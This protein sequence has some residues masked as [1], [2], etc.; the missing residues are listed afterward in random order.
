MT[1][2]PVFPPEHPLNTE[3]KRKGFTNELGDALYRLTKVLGRHNM[4]LASIDLGSWDDGQYMKMSLD[5]EHSMTIEQGL[6][7]RTGEMVNQANVAGVLIRWPT[8]RQAIRDSE[9]GGPKNR[10]RYL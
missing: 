10:F 4:T 7:S 3:D 1:K 8:K 9:F 2:E 6:D 5:V